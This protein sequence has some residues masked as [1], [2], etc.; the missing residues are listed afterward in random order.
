[1]ATKPCVGGCGLLAAPGDVF[2]DGCRDGFDRMGP[3][4]SIRDWPAPADVPPGVSEDDLKWV[5]PAPSWE[6]EPI[7]DHGGV[8]CLACGALA[9][10]DHCGNDY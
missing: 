1:M 4:D 3:D 2:C 7:H 5:D 8:P 9:C 10:C 6:G